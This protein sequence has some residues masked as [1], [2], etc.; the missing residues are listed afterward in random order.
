MSQSFLLTT[1]FLMEALDSVQ[2]VDDLSWP[3]SFY[4]KY[5]SKFKPNLFVEVYVNQK[6]VGRSKTAKKTLEPK[7]KKPVTM[8]VVMLDETK[9][10]FDAPRRSS[11]QESSELIMKLKHESTLPSDPCFGTVKTTVGQLLRLS[12]GLGV[13]R[14]ELEHGTK[15]T[16]YDAHGFISA[17]IKISNA[18]QGRENVLADIRGDLEGQHIASPPPMPPVPSAAEG[19]ANTISE[20]ED[21]LQSLGT[22]LDKIKLIADATVGMVDTLAKVHPY[23]DTAWK[24][25]S[26]LY[27]AYKQQKETDA[28]V[29]ALFK[30]MADCTPSWTTLKA[31]RKKSID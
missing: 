24:V 20:N 18:V 5:R 31:Y 4:S 11:A 9:R 17:G 1:N 29:L 3:S 26:S 6:Q 14:L 15:R 13:A 8:Y 30:K 7:W 27:K 28:A 2:S 23:A 19:L 10:L 25:L 21:L 12:E 22:V 16:M